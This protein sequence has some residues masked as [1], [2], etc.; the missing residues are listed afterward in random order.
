VCVDSA[1]DPANESE[2]LEA[3]ND[4]ARRFNEAAERWDN[5]FRMHR[6]SLVKHYIDGRLSFVLEFVAGRESGGANLSAPSS[7]HVKLANVLPIILYI[8]SD[9]GDFKDGK[10]EHVLVPDIQLVKGVDDLPLPSLVGLQIGN[11]KIEQSGTE[12]FYFSIAKSG[13]YSLTGLPD[14]EARVIGNG[15]RRMMVKELVP[16]QVES[17]SEVVN[18]ISDNGSK[19]EAEF[20]LRSVIENQLPGLNIRILD[21]SIKV[22]IDKGGNAAFNLRDVMFGPFNF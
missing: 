8:H 21:E 10:Q 7:D 3:F 2:R 18:S 16:S 20:L 1:S 5:R 19:L 12:P 17:S 11:Y 9:S 6:D 14:W 22:G 15:S 13:Y 4:A